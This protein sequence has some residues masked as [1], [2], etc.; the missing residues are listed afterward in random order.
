MARN[1]WLGS[2]ALGS[3][4][5]NISLGQPRAAGRA[6]EIE[7]AHTGLSREQS[8]GL[9]CRECHKRR[10]NNKKTRLPGNSCPQAKAGGSRERGSS[11]PE[12]FGAQAQHPLSAL[13]TFHLGLIEPHIRNPTNPLIFNDAQSLMSSCSRL[14][15]GEAGKFRKSGC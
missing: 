11:I 15:G 5:R 12:G 3:G 8:F 4:M 6:Q 14:K 7:A 13:C 9:V 2:S 1:I 10:E